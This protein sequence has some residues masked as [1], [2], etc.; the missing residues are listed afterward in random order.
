MTHTSASFSRMHPRLTDHA[1]TTM[2]L[3]AMAAAKGMAQPQCIAVVDASGVVLAHLRM[4]GAK[5]LSLHSAL[6][7]AETAVS[8]N[9][10]THLVPSGVAGAIAA[11]TGGR[12]TSLPGGL[13]IRLAGHLV[14]GIG[15]GSGTGAQDVAVARAALHAIGAEVFEDLS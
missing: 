6:S 12:V 2:L 11:A 3:A 9:A 4:D 10:P 15:I 1:V 7:K 13:P 8:I 14:G 5:V